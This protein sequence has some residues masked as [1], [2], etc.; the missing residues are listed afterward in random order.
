MARFHF[1]TVPFHAGELSRTLTRLD[2]IDQATG[3]M[4]A[5]G[6]SNEIRWFR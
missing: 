5:D 2:A 1:A 4:R 3:L 6:S